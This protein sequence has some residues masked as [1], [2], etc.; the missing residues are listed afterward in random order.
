MITYAKSFFGLHLLYR[1]DNSSLEGVDAKRYPISLPQLIV[2]NH[3]LHHGQQVHFCRLYGSA[4][5]RCLP[6]GL[7]SG[8]E[9]ALLFIFWGQQDK[10]AWI[11]PYPFALSAF[12]VGFVVVYRQALPCG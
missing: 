2:A 11:Q 4:F 10:D 1:Y 5:L 8:A 7:L 12:I 6:F 3:R 9:T